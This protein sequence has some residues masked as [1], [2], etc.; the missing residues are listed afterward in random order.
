MSRADVA[1]QVDPAAVRKTHIEYRNVRQSRRDTTDGL[2][3]S[4]R[5]T[6]HL[7]VWFRV[8]QVRNTSTHYL[9]IVD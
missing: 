8:D 3:T 1:T 2:T 4:A 5:L 6:H 7:E 9:V